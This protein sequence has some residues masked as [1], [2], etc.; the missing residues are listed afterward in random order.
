MKNYRLLCEAQMEGMDH[1]LETPNLSSPEIHYLQGPFMMADKANK[2]N[3]IYNLT[4][5]TNE[6][7]RYDKE[8]I[9]ASRAVGELDHPVNSTEVTL[10]N[11]AHRIVR[12]ER[13][14]NMFYGKTQLLSTPMGLIA[15]T[16][17]K[18]DIKLGI[19]TRALGKLK[20]KSGVS[21]VEGFRLI[22]LDVVHEPSAPAMLEAVME[23]KRFLIA[24]GGLIM[25]CAYEEL[26]GKVASMP[27]KDRDAYIVESFAQFF[28]RLRA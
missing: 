1:I 8:Y 7:D 23:N 19:S 18:E 3:R 25:E 15:Q 22:C 27:K 16:L 6:V 11:A 21:L 20:P 26:R 17:L 12:L 9:Q 5:M 4:E 13:K 24:Q 2:N 10:K 14:D 28:R